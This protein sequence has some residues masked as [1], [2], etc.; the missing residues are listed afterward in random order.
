MEC[1]LFAKKRLGIHP[2]VYTTKA[3]VIF[4]LLN[5]NIEPYLGT[6]P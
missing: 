4:F 6:L 1:I 5:K 3:F 2:K